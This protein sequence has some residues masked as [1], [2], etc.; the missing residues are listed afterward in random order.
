MFV[1]CYSNK[2]FGEHPTNLYGRCF[3]VIKKFHKFSQPVLSITESY[4]FFPCVK[5]LHII[6]LNYFTC[7]RSTK[8][9]V[10][11]SCSEVMQTISPERPSIHLTQSLCHCTDPRITDQVSASP[12]ETV[13]DIFEEDS[14]MPSS[15]SYQKMEKTTTFLT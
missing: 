5:V 11:M 9:K 13:Q 2:I 6:M 4:T 12:R 10:F 8:F 7:C 15:S 14:D 3:L 1:T